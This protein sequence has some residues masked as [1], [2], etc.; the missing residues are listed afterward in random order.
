MNKINICTEL[1]I[2]VTTADQWWSKTPPI[3]RVFL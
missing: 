1:D 3:V 2:F